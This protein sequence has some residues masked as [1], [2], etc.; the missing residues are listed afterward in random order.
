MYRVYNGQCDPASNKNSKENEHSVDNFITISML[1]GE[2]VNEDNK[3]KCFM[4]ND[5]KKSYLIGNKQNT[6]E[7]IS[8]QQSLF[9]PGESLNKSTNQADINNAINFKTD[10]DNKNI[11]QGRNVDKKQEHVS[12]IIACT[13]KKDLENLSFSKYQTK[14][15]ADAN[16]VDNDA[17]IEDTENPKKKKF[18]LTELVCLR[19]T[20]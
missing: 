15:Q 12:R 20:L 11:I 3:L 10:D 5:S 16:S 6:H 14:D 8:D 1:E 2:E 9:G 13:N 19:Q 17:S 18:K 4:D 7:V